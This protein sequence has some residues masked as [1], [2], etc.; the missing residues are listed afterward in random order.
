MMLELTQG[1]DGSLM[2][3]LLTNPR[4]VAAIDH[5]D[6]NML[7]LISA[8][9]PLGGLAGILPAPWV[10][11]K[12][13]RRIAV[14]CGALC[15][16]TGGLVQT[17]T[18]GGTKMLAGRLIVGIGS[19]FQG[20]GCPS[21]VAETAH[22]RNR[23]QTAA[24]INTCWYIGS[25]IAAWTVFG[26]LDIQG[27]WSWRLCCLVQILPCVV[28]LGLLY[29]TEESPRWLIRNGKEDQAL[30]ILARF[31]ANGDQ[32]DELVQFEFQEISEA[33]AAEQVATAGVSLRS[34]TKSKGNRHRLVILI[35]SLDRD[36]TGTFN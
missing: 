31:H 25:I 23:A 11:D 8:A 12:F 20:I 16:I 18:T 34:F 9:Y 36:L 21:W 1:Y 4:F 29:F 2:N 17:F 13:G 30:R 28:Q 6:A 26:A 14:M 15:I 35:V 19:S 24:L 3:G 33:I 32:D 27:S 10:A 5:P 22:P 7:G